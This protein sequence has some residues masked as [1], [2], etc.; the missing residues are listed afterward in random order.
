MRK[1]AWRE[2][3]EL[4]E[5]YKQLENEHARAREVRTS[6]RLA[7]SHYLSPLPHPHHPQKT[8]NQIPPQAAQRVIP[9]DISMG[10]MA[11]EEARR[12]LNIK[13]RC[14]HGWGV[15]DWC[16]LVRVVG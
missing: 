4:A 16:L 3:D 7:S 14:V 8:L 9:R 5:Q 2:G 10:I 1:E 11:M 13:V 6:R 12:A 15:F